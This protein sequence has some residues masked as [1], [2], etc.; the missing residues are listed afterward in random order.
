MDNDFYDERPEQSDIFLLE[1]EIFDE[2]TS[3]F[4]RPDII[5]LLSGAPVPSLKRDIARKL[6]E[7][8]GQPAD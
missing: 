5:I 4:L 3:Y 8:H 6:A 2:E 1:R 7:V